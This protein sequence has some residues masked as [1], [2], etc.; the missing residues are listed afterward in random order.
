LTSKLNGN[1]L[2]CKNSKFSHFSATGSTRKLEIRPLFSDR[3]PNS[4]PNDGNCVRVDIKFGTGG[5]GRSPRVSFYLCR[6]LNSSEN[7]DMERLSDR[8]DPSLAAQQIGHLQMMTGNSRG[9]FDLSR[10]RIIAADLGNSSLRLGNSNLGISTMENS[11]DIISVN[12][13]AKGLL[14]HAWQCMAKF[15]KIRKI[16]LCAKFLFVDR[17]TC[18]LV[19]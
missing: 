9:N 3:D 1:C 6:N 15:G 10:W 12:T 18:I 14:T 2:I 5:T 16:Y 17:F 8:R 19:T 7:F 4:R 13:H 11:A